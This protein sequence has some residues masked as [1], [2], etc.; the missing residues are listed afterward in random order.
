MFIIT[1]YNKAL[2]IRQ[3]MR[4]RELSKKKIRTKNT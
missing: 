3:L 2:S 1:M 4:G